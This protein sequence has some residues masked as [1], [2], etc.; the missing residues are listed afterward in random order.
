MFGPALL[1]AP[2]LAPGVAEW[3][4]YLPETTGGWFDFWTGAHADGGRTVQAAAPLERI[5]LF[6]RAGSILPLG[7]TDLQFATQRPDAPIELR[8]YPGADAGFTFYE[9]DN[10]TYAY[11]HGE[12]A[13]VELAWDDATKTLH[14]GARQG[15]FPG[16]VAQRE[17]HLIL[18]TSTGN[19]TRTVAYDGAAVDV[20]FTP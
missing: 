18:I 3:P 4:T 6:V 9:D 16:L 12:R 20:K 14:V 10:E 11:E 13:T 7:P 17:F 15:S 5:P 1:V 19:V 8:I 2:V